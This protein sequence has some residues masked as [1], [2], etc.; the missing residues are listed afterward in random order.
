MY[1]VLLA[2]PIGTSP[3]AS[4]SIW[5]TNYLSPKLTTLVSNLS[6]RT[7]WYEGEDRHSSGGVTGG[8]FREKKI[9]TYDLRSSSTN[10]HLHFVYEIL[11]RL[12]LKVRAKLRLYVTMGNLRVRIYFVLHQVIGQSPL[13]PNPT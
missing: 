12:L 6:A 9:D 3:V 1:G 5:Q 2:K 11:D 13:P 10:P 7:S 8:K 4:N